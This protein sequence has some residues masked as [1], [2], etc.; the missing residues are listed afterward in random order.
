MSEN[1][2]AGFERFVDRIDDI[3]G[4]EVATG[5]WQ[6]GDWENAEEKAFGEFMTNTC[7]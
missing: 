3:D 7:G 1:A 2:R 5:N 6:F 4:G